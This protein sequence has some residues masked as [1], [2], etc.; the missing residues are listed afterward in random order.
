MAGKPGRML[1]HGLQELERRKLGEIVPAAR[2]VSNGSFLASRGVAV[3]DPRSGQLGKRRQQG[4]AEGRG[5]QQAVSSMVAVLVSEPEKAFVLRHPK[6]V[7]CQYG[8]GGIFR[9]FAAPLARIWHNLRV[10]QSSGKR[11]AV[12]TLIHA[13][14]CQ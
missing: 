9:I 7:G 13:D 6:Q 2:A 3:A 11:R 5:N 8:T 1:R 10:N 12:R 14:E 4:D